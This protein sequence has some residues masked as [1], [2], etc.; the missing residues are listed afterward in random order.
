MTKQIILTRATDANDEPL[1]GALAYIYQEGTT[2]DVTAYQ[3]AALSTPHAQPIVADSE[4]RF[5]QAFTDGSVRLKVVYKTSGGSTFL[6]EDPAKETLYDGSNADQIGYDGSTSGLGSLNV[7]DAIDEVYASVTNNTANAQTL[8]ATGGTSNTYTLTAASTIT[9]YAVGQEFLLRINHAN[10]G[11]AT[12]NVDGLG[13]K[14]I[15]KYDGAGSLTDLVT[16]DL[17]VDGIKSV[18]YDGTRFILSQSSLTAKGTFTVTVEDSATKGAGGVSPTTATGTF[19]RTGDLINYQFILADVD[20]TGLT[21]G[22]NIYI[23]FAAL[24]DPMNAFSKTPVDRT[25]M[26]GGVSEFTTS[27]TCILPALEIGGYVTIKEFTAG[28]VLANMNVSQ[29]TSGSADIWCSGSF[30]V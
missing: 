27:A 18:F 1:S 5:A 17:R 2:A 30:Q 7:Q 10:T 8:T 13:A 20:T 28:S 4:G 16:G 25:F 6:T 21:G 9:A 14:S 26:S 11:A 3:E 15:Q 23:H 22:N 24:S 12:L 29:I 19:T